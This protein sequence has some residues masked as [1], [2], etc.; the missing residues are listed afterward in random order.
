MAGGRTSLRQQGRTLDL[1]AD[2][3]SK[4]VLTHCVQTLGGRNGPEICCRG[5]SGAVGGKT[6]VWSRDITATIGMK[7]S[8]V[9]AP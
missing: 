2:R 7:N 6:T 9:V 3:P 8:A 1:N 5:V 4:T